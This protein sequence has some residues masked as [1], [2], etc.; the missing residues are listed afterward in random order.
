LY[1]YASCEQPH[2]FVEAEMCNRHKCPVNCVGKF[3]K[4]S[5]CSLKCGGGVRS[6]RYHIEKSVDGAGHDCPFNQSEVQ[7]TH[8]NAKPCACVSIWGPWDKCDGACDESLQRRYFNVLKAADSGGHCEGKH[9]DEETRQCGDVRVRCSVDC[10][11]EF[12]EWGECSA[13]CGG[14]TQRR[15]YTVTI[16]AKGKG[17]ACPK[18]ADEVE[19]LICNA[20]ACPADCAGKWTPWNDCS[21]QCRDG[22]GGGVQ[23][24]LFLLHKEAEAGG[25]CDFV[26]NEKQ[27]RPCNEEKVCGARE[28]V[29]AWSKWGVCKANDRAA[30]CGDGTR[31]KRYI[32]KHAEDPGGK[33]CPQPHGHTA[34]DPCYAGE[35]SSNC[36]G[37]WGEWGACSK[38]ECGGPDA[39]QARTYA[40]ITPGEGIRMI[41]CAQDHGD[42]EERLCNQDLPLCLEAA[43]EDA[44]A[45]EA[46]AA[47]AAAN[48]AAEAEEAA[49]EA[50]VEEAAAEA[51]AAEAASVV[52]LSAAQKAAMDEVLE[53]IEMAAASK[54]ATAQKC[55]GSWGKWSSCTKPCSGGKKSRRFHLPRS[56]ALSAPA[57]A[58]AAAH[59]EVQEAGCN[60]RACA[61][62]GDCEGAW[63]AW[64]DC[65]NDCGLGKKTRAYAVLKEAGHA[66][67][68]CAHGAGEVQTEPCNGPLCDD[69]GGGG[70]GG[71]GGRVETAAGGETEEGGAE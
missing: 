29:G 3:G 9:G 51:A 14:G 56:L 41:P 66:G 20:Q 65:S 7:E 60:E 16:K 35:C 67:E 23:H 64:G 24:R 34:E 69:G 32:V 15:V 62:G 12:S 46:A 59:N 13:D 28:C 22:D 10:A 11:G 50:A 40:M 70:G 6:R 33:A 5:E 44:A 31:T 17:A 43:V 55:P 27:T 1:R 54:L 37:K 68:P 45:K 18:Q 38:S 61:T 48:K 47:E 4:W 21:K 58:C 25:H 36:V 52:P 2:D 26:D 30:G 8:C 19:E 57:A 63:G 71:E 49:A 53:V 42:V 39:K